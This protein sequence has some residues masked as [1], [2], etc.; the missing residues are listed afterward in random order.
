MSSS[1]PIGGNGASRADWMQH[2]ARM[3]GALVLA[4]G[5][6]VPA[7]GAIGA[8]VR[9]G[10][11][12]DALTLDP[13]NHRKRETETIIRNLRAESEQVR[14]KHGDA[15]TEDFLVGLMEQHEKMAWMLRSYLA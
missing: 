8:E 2:V 15:G 12:Q 1:G 9:V 10:Y 11:T 6:A 13:A 5:L 14:E 4:C 3:L 7:A